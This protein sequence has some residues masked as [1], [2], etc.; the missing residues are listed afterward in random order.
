MREAEDEEILEA[1]DQYPAKVERVYGWE[2][3]LMVGSARQPTQI[4]LIQ[5]RSYHFG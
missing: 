3:E 5:G 1:H 2:V 4:L